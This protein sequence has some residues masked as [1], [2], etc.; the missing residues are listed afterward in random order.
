[1]HLIPDKNK[2][3]YLLKQAKDYETLIIGLRTKRQE[4]VRIINE[5]NEQKYND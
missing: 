3:I 4:V 1:M 2:L 5:L